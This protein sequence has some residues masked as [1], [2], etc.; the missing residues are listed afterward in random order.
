MVGGVWLGFVIFWHLL[1]HGAVRFLKC[2]CSLYVVVVILIL[3]R[4][5]R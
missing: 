4:Y 2:K 5:F 1:T 3:K